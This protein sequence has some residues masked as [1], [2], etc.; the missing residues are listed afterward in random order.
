MATTLPPETES[1]SLPVPAPPSV[2]YRPAAGSR[3]PRNVGQI[4][5]VLSVAAG[6]ALLPRGFRQ[7]SATGW[8]LAAVGAGLLYRGL[9]GHCAAYQGLGISTAHPEIKG[10]GVPAQR[11]FRYER[12]ILI[13]RSAADLY[14][15]WRR[16][17]NLSALTG[18]L[19]S[20]SPTSP[21]RTRWV[22]EG[23]WGKRVE[24][25]AEVFN[26]KPDELIAWRS[27][28]D[29]ELDTAGSVHFTP[30]PA[31]RGTLLTVLLKY[32]TPGGRLG[33]T[34]A[35]LLGHGFES[36]VDDAL[37]QF[38]QVMEAGETPRTDPSVRGSCQR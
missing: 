30:A 31:D 24:W 23:P 1:C 8:G 38:K 12:S 16:P 13:Q 21:D 5:R 27:L 7:K 14:Q 19:V 25:E 20:I 28:P 2:E 10:K 29:S 36:Q 15:A 6:T 9:T 3:R 11:G 17:E 22:A 18:H 26:D 34:L 33:A 37:R 32:D 4:E 35:G